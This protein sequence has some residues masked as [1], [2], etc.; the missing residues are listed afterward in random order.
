MRYEIVPFRSVGSLNIG[1]AKTEVRKILGT[2]VLCPNKTEDGKHT[3]EFYQDADVFTF[4]DIGGNAEAFEFTGDKG[5]Y[6]DNCDL[7]T[8]SKDEVISLLMKYDSD[9]C[10]EDSASIDFTK[11]G[12]S[13]YIPLGEDV[14]A[15]LVFKKG[16]YD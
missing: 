7:F 11:I 2:S 13:L 4:Y 6:F 14:E 16:Y 5:V 9:P 12:I 15:I 1:M 8:S 3:T 10:T